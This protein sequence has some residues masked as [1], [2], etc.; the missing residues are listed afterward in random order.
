MRAIPPEADVLNE[1]DYDSWHAAAL[2]DPAG[3]AAYVIAL[4]GDPV[5]KA[6]AAHPDGLEELSI[7]CGTGQPCARMYQSERYSTVGVPVQK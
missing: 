2:E 1:S 5:A 6:V 4:D 7:T 3:K